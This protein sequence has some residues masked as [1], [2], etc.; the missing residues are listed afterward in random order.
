VA[1]PGSDD[2]TV[3]RPIDEAHKLP[4]IGGAVELAWLPEHCRAFAREDEAV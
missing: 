4:E 1:L 2:F 3:K